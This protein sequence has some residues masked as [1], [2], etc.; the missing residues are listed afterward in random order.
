MSFVTYENKN[1]PHV[2]VHVDGC[3]QIAK[4]GG[5]H[6]YGQGGYRRHASGMM[7]VHSIRDI[8]V[9]S[10]RKT[11]GHLSHTSKKRVRI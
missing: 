11:F 3:N 7:F 9:C 10:L 2:T 5:E 6:K 4:H 1:N 8:F